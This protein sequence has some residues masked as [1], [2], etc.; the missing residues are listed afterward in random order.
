MVV[1]V[2]ESGPDGEAHVPELV[3]LFVF[4]CIPDGYSA[5]VQEYE[6]KTSLAE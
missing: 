2:F 6:T 3:L 5:L 1:F 4:V